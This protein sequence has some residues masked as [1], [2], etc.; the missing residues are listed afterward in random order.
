MADT[1]TGESQDGPTARRYEEMALLR[2]P[3]LI[4]ARLWASMTVPSI[5]P[6]VGSNYT[7]HLPQPYSG[8]NGRAVLHLSSKLTQAHMPAGAKIFRLNA[9]AQA[10]AKNGKSSLTEQQERVLSLT[11]DIVHQEIERC[12]W[13]A[14]INLVEQ[15]LI[16]TG[17]CLLQMMP[18]NKLRAFRLD[19]YVVHRDGFGQPIEIILSEPITGKVPESL[20]EYFNTQ[21]LVNRSA[22]LF[23]HCLR[24]ETTH[25]WTVHQEAG[26]KEVAGSRGTYAKDMLP[27]WPLRWAELIG[28]NYGRAKCE[29][30]EADHRYIEH[31]T[32]SVG[33]G[34]AIA[35]RALIMLKPNAAG[36]LNL[37]RRLRDARNGDVVVGDF[38]D[39]DFKS[40]QNIS[41]FQ[42]GA[43]ELG[44]IKKEIASA[45]L[46]NS[47]AQRDAERVT[48]YE[49][50]AM[51]E[52]IEGTLGGVYSLQAGEMVQ[53]LI[54]RL[55]YQMAAKGEMPDL[56]QGVVEP[57]ILTGLAA[58][59]R[60]S[61]LQKIQMILGI[62]KEAPPGAATY[63]NFQEVMQ[64]LMVAAG[65]ANCVFSEA[66]VEK[67]QQQAHM[68]QMM[69]NAAGPVAGQVAG[70]M[71]NGAQPQ[72]GP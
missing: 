33:D 43:T 37:R 26:G 1:T 13:R 17:N 71:A 34:A 52:E 67:Q 9:T 64:R 70:A 61:D 59:G 29:E 72:T 21:D 31:L 56:G 30:H 36:G 68:M 55:M 42:F 69:Q 40:F 51:I 18:D 14:K 24:D 15:N 32:H 19:Q 44:E 3:F 45:Y 27:F 54:K 20:Q 39:V 58:L 7:Q 63:I 62:A 38:G 4:R 65:L 35:A 46:M 10:L 28:E 23:T 16:V 49:M 50:K 48:A 60:E 2:H 22:R 47:A 6:P 66:D 5:L 25:K 12:V 8:F 57:T 11:E 53:P 41:G